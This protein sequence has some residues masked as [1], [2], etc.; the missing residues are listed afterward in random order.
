MGPGEPILRGY[1]EVW[2]YRTIFSVH[3]IHEATVPAQGL[4][5]QIHPNEER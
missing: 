3:S 4:P 2:S 5:H 1:C